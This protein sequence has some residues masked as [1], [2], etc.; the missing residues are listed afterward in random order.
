VIALV[1][2]KNE[3]IMAG[4]GQCIAEMIAAK[5]YN[6]NEG[7]AVS[8]TYGAVTTGHVWKFLKL[9][10]TTVYIDIENYYIANPKKIVG[11]FAYMIKTA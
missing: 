9:Q 3:R 5:L 1:E 11:I 2:A 6:E 8:Y 10:G 7:K 4:V